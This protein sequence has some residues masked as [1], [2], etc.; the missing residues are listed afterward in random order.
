[1]RSVSGPWPTAHSSRPSLGRTH[2]SSAGSSRAWRAGGACSSAA[3]ARA[4][5][6]PDT[7]PPD[8]PRSCS[9]RR[10]GGAGHGKGDMS[11][12]A[13]PTPSPHFGKDAS[14]RCWEGESTGVAPTTRLAVKTR[15]ASTALGSSSALHMTPDTTV[16]VASSPVCCREGGGGGCWGFK[17]TVSLWARLCDDG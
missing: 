7:A 17:W 12:L 3:H 15:T 10:Q 8:T 16:P 9:F 11:A 2:R 13:H 5:C 14:H 6:A 1:M 4:A